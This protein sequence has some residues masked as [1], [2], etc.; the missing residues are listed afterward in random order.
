MTNF[1]TEDNHVEGGR[2]SNENRFP[3]SYG[4]KNPVYATYLR[5][6]LTNMVTVPYETFTHPVACI[7]AVSSHNQEPIGCLRQLYE[8]TTRNGGSLPAWLDT[9]CLRYYVLIHDEDKDDIAKSTALFDLM[10]RNFGLH[11]YLL[12]LKSSLS[13]QTD[14]DTIPFSVCGWVSDVETAEQQPLGTR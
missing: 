13:L 6:L 9:D 1:P 12:R 7:I 8:K 10:K 3:E 4:T 5:D 14:D 11:C 2:E